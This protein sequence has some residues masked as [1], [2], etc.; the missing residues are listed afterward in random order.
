MM[1]DGKLKRVVKWIERDGL[2]VFKLAETKINSNE[3]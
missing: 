3:E 2:E 1:H